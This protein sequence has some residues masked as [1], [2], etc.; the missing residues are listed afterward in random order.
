MK[1]M[2]VPIAILVL[3]AGT[4]SGA[5]GQQVYRCKLADGSTVFSDLP[6]LSDT[7]QADTVDATPHQGH[8]PAPEPGTP[9]YRMSEVERGSGDSGRPARSRG[10]TLSRDERLSLERKR[11]SLLSGLK[12]RHVT[13]GARKSMIRQLRAVDRRLGID[14]GDV[15]D[16]P[17]HNREVY[18]DHPVFR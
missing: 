1:R 14:A 3:L 9:A 18:E 10:R 6:C 16:M 8:R 7:G 13:A 17:Y 4:W 5:A 11:Q 2:I 12:R 15:A